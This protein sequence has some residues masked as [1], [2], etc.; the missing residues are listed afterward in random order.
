MVPVWMTLS[1]LWPR[2]Q[3]H[4]IIQRQIT[5]KQYQIELYLQWRTNR[6]SYRDYGLL[7]GRTAPFP[8]TLNDPYPQ[9]Q[10][11]AIVDVEYLQN[12]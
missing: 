7:N 10:G 12:G 3:G 1:D 11:Q 9:F 4:D 8:M 5:Q 6:K 2:F